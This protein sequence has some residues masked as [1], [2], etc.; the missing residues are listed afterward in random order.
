MS[1]NTIQTSF[2]S[3]ELAPSISAR[4]DLA[5]YHSGAMLLRN[6]FVDYRSGASTKPGSRFVVQALQSA[7]AV[8][9][10]GYQ[11]S[12][13]ISYIIEFGN[14]YCRFITNGGAVLETGYAITGATNTAP[15][16]ITAVG[17]NFVNGD[18]VFVTG[19]VGATLYNGR[20]F[21]VTVSGNTVTLFDVRGVAIDASAYGTYLSGGTISRVYKI[22][23][24]Y[25]ASD[26]NQLKFVQS[27][28]VMTITHPDYVPY[29]LTATAAT[30]WA[31]T[32]ITFGTTATAP[33]NVAASA[34]SAG[35]T[36]YAY[37][38]T[39]VDSNGQESIASTIYNLA[40]A[41]NVGATAGTITVT[42]TAAAGAASYN[43]YK[44]EISFT[45]AV[46]VGASFGFIG[47]ATGASF[48]DSNIVP[49]FSVSPPIVDNPFA[50]LN[51]PNCVC[52]FQ[53]RLTFAGSNAN[54]TTFWMSQPGSFYNF[55]YSNPTQDDDAITGNIVSL[56]VNAIRSM[57]PMPGGL[58][59]LTT[60]G[61]WQVSG[62]GSAQTSTGITPVNATAVPQAYNG[63]HDHLQPIVCGSDV[64]YVQSKG[65]IV[66]DLSY[67]I[68]ANIYTGTDISVLS[69]HLFLG[70]QIT[71]WAYAE[72]PYKII[73]A[74]RNDGQLLNLTYMKE[75]E[76]YGWAH[77]DT[78]GL[79]KSVAAITEGNIDAVYVVVDRYLQG[80]W[81]KMIERFDDRMFTYSDSNPL[82]IKT[83]PSPFITANAESSWCVDCGVQSA[84]TEP[85]AGLTA[86]TNY[87]AVT[88]TADA[89]VFT[90]SNVNS[91]LRM[92]GGTATITEF[93]SATIIK[94]T[95]KASPSKILPNDPAKTPIPAVAGDWSLA[96]LFTVFT[97]LDY[98][99]G[100]T[101]SILADGGVVTPQV[102]VDGS[103]TLTNPASLV[104]VG[105]GFQA[106]I[107]TMNLDIGGGAETIQGK[108][109]KIAA[110]SVRC[111]NSRGL[112]AGRT[113]QTAVQIKELNPN[114]IL[115]A[116][117]PLITGDE[118]VVM[119][120]LWDT[121]GRICIQQDDPLPATVLGVIPEI[122]VG[123]TK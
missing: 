2:A 66:R 97:G 50:S 117:I 58:I 38:I 74:V 103:I 13:S 75:Q 92:G 70:Y 105:L 20:Y 76:I 77:C 56:E 35:T 48:I 6:F 10:I 109:K 34:S 67:N 55:N 90:S 116:P 119:D 78:L 17:N 18:W 54:P 52:Y 23:S 9:L 49:D 27:A 33:T 102:V 113:F 81:V 72:E 37:L 85:S 4:T 88:F 19:I 43:I 118:R 123:D 108:R 95:W 89:G 61:A 114:V 98:L 12:S 22:T 111:A 84:L 115:G 29:N 80:R 28:S 121:P 30:N 45:A 79:Y 15:G 51:N 69:N 44:A 31:F 1:N 40:A 93:I 104:T 42:W 16:T 112:K 8:R 120:P 96:P 46:P 26:L 32:A 110:L 71:E 86:D 82:N 100:Q 99:E 83:L 91:I 57:V 14:F 25:A 94:G 63:A 101:V 3:G 36:N 59:M 53:Q 21:S 87:G 122:L 73:W 7:T 64:V 65:S 47:S 60:K 107:Q 11:F 41:V 5:K 39:T 24:P 68:Y 62:G 106:Q